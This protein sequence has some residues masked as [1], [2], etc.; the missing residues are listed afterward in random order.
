MVALSTYSNSVDDGDT[1]FVV[2]NL[3]GSVW[4]AIGGKFGGAVKYWSMLWSSEDGEA[5]NDDL[6]PPESIDMLLC[7][8]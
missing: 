1:A 2:S 8:E 7:P 4:S 3:W 6:T 5:A